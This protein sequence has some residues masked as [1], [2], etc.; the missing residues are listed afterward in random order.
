MLRPCRYPRVIAARQKVAEARQGADAPL[1]RELAADRQFPAGKR[2]RDPFQSGQRPR[3]GRRRRRP[4][5]AS[6]QES[7]LARA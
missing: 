4:S 6:R 7:D 5:C 1:E 3:I 2:R